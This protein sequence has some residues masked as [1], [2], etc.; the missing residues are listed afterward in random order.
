MESAGVLGIVDRIEAG[1]ENLIANYIFYF[2]S[3]A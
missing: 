3:I 2:L 1:M